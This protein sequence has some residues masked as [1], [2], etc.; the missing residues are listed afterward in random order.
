MRRLDLANRVKPIRGRIAF[1]VELPLVQFRQVVDV[2]AAYVAFIGPRVDGDPVTARG[3]AGSG[4]LQHIG[5]GAV[6]GV[7][8]QGYFVD[9]DAQLDHSG[10]ACDRV[11]PT[12][13]KPVN[14]CSL[15]DS[16]PRRSA[17]RDAWETNPPSPE[18]A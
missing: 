12:E 11:K 10:S 1:D 16:S 8:E 6:P 9:V 2:A 18:E 17:L 5:P 3:K 13:N 14:Q 7:A 15:P 4:D